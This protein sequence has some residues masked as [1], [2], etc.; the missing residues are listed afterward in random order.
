VS[1]GLLLC[2]DLLF[3]SKVTATAA[4][5]GL[6]VAVRKSPEALL[7]AATANPPAGVIV[8]LN[9]PGLEMGVFVPRMKALGPVRVIGFGSHVD[10]ET[11]DAAMSAGC[12][13]V[14]P[15]SKFVQG[16]EENL[17]RWFS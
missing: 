4:A 3:A 15:R 6:S 12:D 14:M 2:D 16:L 1:G 13:E 8:D 11:L 7:A 5:H 17:P 10:K 9:T